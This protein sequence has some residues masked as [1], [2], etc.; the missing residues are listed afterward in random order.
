[1]FEVFRLERFWTLVFGPSPLDRDK[2]GGG[3]GRNQSL[4]GVV[5]KKS[6]SRVE[7]RGGVGGHKDGELMTKF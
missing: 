4:R 3:L 5:T 2:C 6:W 7:C 1:M